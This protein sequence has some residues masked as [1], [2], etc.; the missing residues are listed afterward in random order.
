MISKF[1]KKQTKFVANRIFTDRKTPSKVFADSI[2][3]LPYDPQEIVVY[4]GKGGIGKTCLLKQLNKLSEETYAS[5]P[6]YHFHNIFLSFDAQNNS[7]E[8]A[9]M[10]VLR[11]KLHGDGGLFDYAVIQY[12]AKSKF[13]VDEIKNKIP[14]LSHNLQKA[15]D[16]VVSLGSGSI[17]I[18]AFVVSESKNLIK[19]ERIINEYHEEIKEMSS[20]TSEELHERLPYYLGICFSVAAQRG[21]IHV[22]F[23][24]SYEQ[25]KAVNQSR[26]WFMEFLASC[27]TLRACIASRDKLKWSIEDEGWDSVLNQHLLANL[28]DEDSR[29]F[30]HQVPINDED[31]VEKIVFHSKGVP[32]FLDMSVDLYQDDI[33]AGRTPDFSKI[34]QGEKLIDRYMNYMDV[35]SAYAIKILS[36]PDCF[37]TDYA[38][39][40]LK[41]QNAYINEEQLHGLFEKSIV[42]SIDEEFDMWKIDES[43]RTHLLEQMSEDKVRSILSDMLSYVQEE[44]GGSAFPYFASILNTV[45]RDPQYIIGLNEAI[46]EQIDYYGNS[47]FWTE[48]NNILEP[49]L[50]SGDINLYT[51]A[52]IAKIIC[53]RRT[54]SL[55]E[56]EAF[57]A[58]HPLDAACLGNYYYMYRYMQIQCRHLQGHYDEALIGYRNLLDDMDLIRCTLPAHIYNTVCMK[59]AD[60]LFLKGMF[61]QSLEITDGLLSSDSL[62]LIDQ[63]ELMRIKGHIFKFQQKYKQAHI[64]YLAA[65]KIVQEKKLNACLG[66]LYTNLAEVSSFSEPE[67]S[68]VWFEKAR[69]INE[70][71]GNLI[72]LGKAYAASAIANANIA[73][74]KKLVG[75]SEADRFLFTALSHANQAIS[76]AKQAGY[77][78]GE[79]FGLI[80]L[81]LAYKNADSAEEY[82][83]TVER[84]AGLLAELGV[85]NFLL[86][87]VE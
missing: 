63:I 7:N 64:I 28:S 13:T 12:L 5:L 56:E 4:Y 17:A 2:L 80:G 42:L 6:E 55:K 86:V 30:L 43:V 18:P 62:S 41:R 52:V 8:I 84:L 29:W 76:F 74:E 38:L 75:G 70:K 78:A 77:R 48:I 68:I 73:R 51:L 57:I 85:Y 81:A 39:Y 53:I 66:K 67:E 60:L 44:E 50:D 69:L 83:L 40:L 46:I 47:G 71:S 79:A 20:L 82:S 27:E 15:L 35:D 49:S 9:V 45:Q 58:T 11:N 26:D 1:A 3:S 32:L 72:E 87:F 65:L 37:N 25:V 33:N 34:R 54:C 59:Y 24:D 23:F 16:E 22:F 14:T 19:D 21:E 36:V 31:V 10:M 61:D